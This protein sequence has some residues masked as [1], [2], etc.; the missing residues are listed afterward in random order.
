MALHCGELVRE[1]A[2]R[3]GVLPLASPALPPCSEQHEHRV[4]RHTRPT[5][6]R[7]ETAAGARF[8]VRRGTPSRAPRACVCERVRGGEDT[9]TQL[10]TI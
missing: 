8:G 10:M 4:G 5:G 2:G 3:Q 1:A 6:T 7:P 9:R